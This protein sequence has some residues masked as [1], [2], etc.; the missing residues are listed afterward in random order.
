MILTVLP[1]LQRSWKMSYSAVLIN[2]NYSTMRNTF[3]KNLST[4]IAAVQSP[5][6]YWEKKPYRFDMK[7]GH[8]RIVLRSTAKYKNRQSPGT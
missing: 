4:Q 1:E 5:T 2:K 6:T 8:H 7:K 3:S